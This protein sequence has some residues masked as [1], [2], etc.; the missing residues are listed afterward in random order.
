[1]EIS[2]FINI[3]WPVIARPAHPTLLWQ[4]SKLQQADA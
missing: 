1:M 3:Q 2:I 4:S